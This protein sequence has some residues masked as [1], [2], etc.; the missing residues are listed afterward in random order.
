MRFL[1]VRERSASV[2]ASLPDLLCARARATNEPWL[3]ASVLSDR[4]VLLGASQRA[5]RVLDLEACA[6]DGVAVVRRAT[7]GTAIHA[8]PGT[9][10][11][12]LAM[13][14]VDTLVADATLRTLINRN[15]RGFLTGITRTGALAQYFG[16]EWIAVQHRPA[17]LLGTHHATDGVVA[18]DVYVANEAT[19]ALPAHLASPLER[20][21]DRWRGKSPIALREIL[22]RGK[23]AGQLAQR[24][25]EGFA[26]R[27]GH[28][29]ESESEEPD[30][31]PAGRV[32]EP[33]DPVPPG[34]RAGPP[35]A[36]SIGHV[37]A[38]WSP[39]ALW[40]GGDALAPRHVLDAIAD[41]VRA[42]DAAPDVADGAIEGATVED[43]VRAARAARE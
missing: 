15:V 28:A 4:A 36:C 13:P 8:E 7:A 19:L 14:R 20:A 2:L 41:F 40:L 18:M 24:I 32:T 25:A 22:A 38:A 11:F 17:A 3:S 35:V 42:S 27:V 43:L 16:R 23:S 1:P 5:G 29:L 9:L 33:D 12:T 26:D 6:R 30:V 37:E 34:L 31:T 39:D 21:T 10:A